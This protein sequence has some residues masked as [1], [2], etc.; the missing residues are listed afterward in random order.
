[1]WPADSVEAARVLYLGFYGELG[2]AELHLL[3]MLDWLDRGRVDPLV[4]VAAEGPFVERLRARHIDVRVLPWLT[5][6]ARGAANPIRGVAQGVRFVRGVPPLARLC[7]TERVTLIHAFAEPAVK[8]GAALALSAHIPALCTLHDALAPPYGHIHRHAIAWCLNHAFL[9]TIVPSEA[10]RRLALE[11][12]VRADA[13]TCVVNAVDLDRFATAATDRDAAR[14]TL[15]FAATDR[16]IGLVA[17]FA[18]LKGHDVLVR[19]LP[20]ILRACP[21]ARV[22]LVGDAL[23]DGEARHKRALRQSIEARG[24][25]DRVRFAGWLDDAAGAYAA[26]DLL[27][28]PCVGHDTLPT[29]ILEAMASGLPVVASAIGGVPELVEDTVTGRL[30]PVGDPVALAGAVT[31]LLADPRVRHEMGAAAQARARHAFSP[32]RYREEMHQRYEAALAA[33]TA[34]AW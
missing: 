14:R 33:R 20:D 22:L 15:G 6:L 1:M 25:G 8:Y 2:G 32:G 13:V 12:G 7:R 3:S 28:H 19:A 23:F 18:P 4:G 26:M 31:T 30:V 17:R 29:V 21:E 34:D 5:Y 10:N 24:L 27:V 9:G 16:V 11:A